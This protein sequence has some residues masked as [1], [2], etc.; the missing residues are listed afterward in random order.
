MSIDYIRVYQPRDA[1]NI[2]CDPHDFPT[3]D[4]INVYVY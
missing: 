2:G 4:Y 3:Q 1:I